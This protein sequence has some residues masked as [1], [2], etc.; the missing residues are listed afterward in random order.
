MSLVL[1]EEMKAFGI[2]VS[3]VMP[4]AT[5]TNSWSG[6]DLPEDRFMKASDVAEAVFMA[7]SLSPTA[8][9]EEILMRPQEGDI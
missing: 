1:R 8:D 3:S 2:K 6:S 4:G 9:V 5:Y 7:A